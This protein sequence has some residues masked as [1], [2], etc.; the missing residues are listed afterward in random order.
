MDIYAHYKKEDRLDSVF[1]SGVA[2]GIRQVATSEQDIMLKKAKDDPYAAMK[3]ML[4]Q[5]LVYVG[6]IKD[7]SLLGKQFVE[8]MLDKDVSYGM[9]QL[10]KHSFSDKVFSFKYEFPME[11]NESEKH[12]EVF[13]YEFDSIEV[14]PYVWVQSEIDRLNNLELGAWDKSM[15]FPVVFESYSLAIEE[16]KNR[17]YIDP[18]GAKIFWDMPTAGTNA[19]LL[20]EQLE[21]GDYLSSVHVR[22]GRINVTID[23]KDENGNKKIVPQSMQWQRLPAKVTDMFVQHFL[24]EEA[25]VD[26]IVTVKSKDKAN[27]FGMVNIISTPEFFTPSLGSS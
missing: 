4:A 15:K 2:F 22:K 16:S 27:K 7:D 18:S 1:P 12:S 10:R 13:H 24:Q 26:T 11:S 23:Q 9:F 6:D 21:V 17:V 3:W 19:S 14:K 25:K 20:A 5:C 8:R